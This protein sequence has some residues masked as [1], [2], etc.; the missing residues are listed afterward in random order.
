[1]K[2]SLLLIPALALSLSA[3]AI[4]MTIKITSTQLQHITGFGAAGCS[5]AMCP[6]QDITV[7]TKLYGPDSPVGLN[8]VRMEMSPNLKGDINDGWDTPYDWHGSLG[9]VGE[10]KRLGAIVYACPWSPPGIYKTNGGANGGNTEDENAVEGRL[11]EDAYP[12]LFP[13][14]NTFLKYMHDNNCDV[15]VVSIQNEPDW[16][17]NYSGCLYEPDD[18]RRLVA[19]YGYKLQKDRY[20]VK[21]MT[22]E[23]LGYTKKYYTPTF[24]DPN[25]C[26][27]IDLAGGHQYGHEPLNDNYMRGTATAARAKNIDSWMTE[28][29]YE[30]GMDYTD[31]GR[32]M[33]DWDH[34]IGFAENVN[35]VIQ[36]G[37]S[38]YVYWYMVA[39]WS[40]IGSGEDKDKTVEGTN[41]Y[42]KLLDRGYIMSHFAKHL[43]GSTRL[44]STLNIPEKTNAIMETTAYIK[45]DSLMVIAINR[46]NKNSYELT[47]NSP[48][49]L[50]S[51]KRIIS[52]EGNLCQEE[53]L[54]VD[55]TST[56]QKYDYPN[57]S[58]ATY[59]FQIDREAMGIEAPKAERQTREGKW[60]NAAGQQV[61]RPTKGI[62]I[63][64]GKKYS[65]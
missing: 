57:M 5:G 43:P 27:Y 16:W 17:V 37:G 40:F 31:N 29:S 2:K 61:A 33:P 38:A 63:K 47:I 13:W 8:I 3:G 23:P 19:D 42:G 22:A 53:Q 60:Y 7:A 51:G 21:L 46:M 58:I 11:R 10:A 9:I 28:Y 12:K 25:A 50:K 48:Y 32:H 26:Q 59:I 36:A 1:M 44:K 54:A 15:D 62:F 64:D 24:D 4:N 35:E 56:I 14:F 49:R 20:N 55:T 52:T 39:P 65:F 18:L 41:Q 6:I 30:E 34:Q 45:G